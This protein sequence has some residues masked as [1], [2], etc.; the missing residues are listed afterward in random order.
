MEPVWINSI[1]YESVSIFLQEKNAAQPT[2]VKMSEVRDK[3]RALF[4]TGKPHI[5]EE[6]SPDFPLLLDK[7]T[8]KR[9]NNFSNRKFNREKS[10]KFR[11]DEKIRK[12]SQE[13][14]VT[15]YSR[16]KRSSTM[17][18]DCDSC[19]QKPKKNAS[20]YLRT[21]T[22]WRRRSVYHYQS[23]SPSCW[24]YCRCCWANPTW[25]HCG[26]S[27]SLGGGRTRTWCLRS[28]L[29]FEYDISD[30]CWPSNMISSILADLGTSNRTSAVRRLVVVRRNDD[31][32]RKRAPA[33]ST[34]VFIWERSLLSPW[35]VN[36]YIERIKPPIHSPLVSNDTLSKLK[37]RVP[38][39]FF[40]GSCTQDRFIGKD[41]KR[42]I[43]KII[44]TQK[45]SLLMDCSRYDIQNF[46]AENSCDSPPSCSLTCLRVKFD[47]GRCWKFRVFL[48]PWPVS[49]FFGFSFFSV[50]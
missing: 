41:S 44:A 40:F 16:A 8:G 20:K 21:T 7:K 24:P 14:Q 28:L 39:V 22:S 27:S 19:V 35:G 9:G 23:L 2:P 18:G 50:F 34:G 13:N 1:F 45:T 46:I 4:H 12:T 49:F 3:P 33:V 25:W 10:R 11:K 47:P 17:T 43:I 37:T 31:C 15:Q 48:F 32:G 38:T 26:P 30:P 42:P 6:L 36:C 5:V 29:T